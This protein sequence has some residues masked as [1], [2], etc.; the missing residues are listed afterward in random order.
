MHVE[1]GK[2]LGMKRQADKIKVGEQRMVVL[3][4]VTALVRQI[5]AHVHK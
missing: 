3:V 5:R 4:V 1:V 2:V